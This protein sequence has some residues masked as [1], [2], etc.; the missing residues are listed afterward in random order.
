LQIKDVSRMR[1]A[2]QSFASVS[3]AS[4]DSQAAPTSEPR[5]SVGLARSS[6]DVDDALRLR[7]KVFAEELGARIDSADGLDRDGFDDWC[8]HLIVRD[9][10]SLRVIG[11]YRILPPHRARQLGRLYSESEFDLSRLAHLRESMVEIGRSCV[12]RDYRQGPAIM[13]LW[14]GL[15]QYM[16]GNGYRHMVGCASASLADGG[17]Q[18]AAL[19]DSIQALLADPEYRVFPRVPFPHERFERSA[20]CEMPPLIRGYMRLGAQICGE[21]AWDPDFNTADFLVW[22]SLDRLNPRYARHFDLLVDASTLR[23]SPASAAMVQSC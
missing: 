7:Y 9:D 16:R 20:H 22:L 2:T 4:Q 6:A 10:D 12:H 1:T 8:D 3:A 17:A 19:R 11:T 21:P 15:G 14:A 5:L 23:T 13:L 18:A